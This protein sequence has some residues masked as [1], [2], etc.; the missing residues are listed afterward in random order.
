[1][2]STRL[3]DEVATDIPTNGKGSAAPAA[4]P[5]LSFTD[6]HVLG[7]LGSFAALVFGLAARRRLQAPPAGDEPHYLVLN[8]AMRR[9]HTIDPTPVYN[10]RDYW[11]FYAYPLEP[12]V[13]VAPNGATVP[14]HNVGGPLLWHPFYL[15]DGRVGVA[16]FLVA[17][18]VLTVLNVY[19]LMRDLGIVRTY[20]VGVSALLVVG[21]PLYVYSSMVFIEAIGA[22]VVVFAARQVLAPK[23]S[24][25]RLGV[26]SAGLGYLPFV[27]GRFVIITALFGA[28]FLLRIFSEVRWRDL[29]AYLVGLGPL[30]VVL[31][32][33]T[34]FN[35]ASYD[36]ANPAPGN[37]SGGAALLA[38]PLYRGVPSLLFDRIYGL[39]PYFPIF[40][41]AFPGILLTMRRGLL[42]VHVTLLGVTLP[43]L[44]AIGTFNIWWGGYSPPARFLA[45][46]TPLLAY[47]IAVTIQRLHN[48]LVSTLA[49]V[50][51]MA[52]FVISL[53]GDVL[54][55]SRF[56]SGSH[57]R[58][59][60][61]IDRVSGL[62]AVPR[63]SHALPSLLITGTHVGNL[64]KF[65][66][67]AAVLAGFTVV[68]WL[69]GRRSP[70]DRV[71][72]P[73]LPPLAGRLRD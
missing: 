7:L 14:L 31:G 71:P 49:L 69:L 11:S 12:H 22:L 60:L 20:A 59:G 73:A 4:L 40:A 1:M 28:L 23:R 67:W 33:V 25:V 70:A 8:E 52:S 55:G 63:F 16:A 48:W 43:Y 17:V 44:L 2:T 6:R 37:V 15:L 61:L 56:D 13:A 47:Y 45:A 34:V 30:V 29:R 19:W 21:S 39:L 65:A 32:A 66:G 42:W 58:G 54:L 57:D 5:R 68:V 26:A 64:V 24:P 53:A 51:A 41:F 36:T 50:A 3:P 38:V 35:L 72:V 9:Y 27:H 18:S 62:F 10:H 46:V